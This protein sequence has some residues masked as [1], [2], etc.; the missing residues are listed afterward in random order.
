MPTYGYECTACREQFEIV[1]RMTDD[2]LTVHENCGGTLR[3]LMYPVGIVFKG[4]G[5]HVNDYG[6]N[7]KKAGSGKTSENAFEPKAETKTETTTE[8]KADAKTES[9]TESKT[10]TKSE[11]KTETKTTTAATD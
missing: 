2:A 4:S 10:E 6:K 9:K 8:S 5:F 11:T 7:G 1:Q 3:R